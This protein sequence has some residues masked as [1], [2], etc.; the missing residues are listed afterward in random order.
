MK[1]ADSFTG[2][3]ESTNGS[4]VIT[5]VVQGSVVQNNIWTLDGVGG[6]IG[7]VNHY[8]TF[9]ERKREAAFERK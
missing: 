7:G 9:R 3:V 4:F 1:D 2:H 6:W 5:V 8:V